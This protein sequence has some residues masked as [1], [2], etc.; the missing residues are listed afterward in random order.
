MRAYQIVDLYSRRTH[1]R[2]TNVYGS[3]FS[4]YY[5]LL[6]NTVDNTI[7]EDSCR[8]ANKYVNTRFSSVTYYALGSPG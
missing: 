2:A 1:K 6:V 8:N 4:V 3:F 7:A 5:L